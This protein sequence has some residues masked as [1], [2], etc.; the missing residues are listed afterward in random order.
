MPDTKPTKHNFPASVP[1][2][3]A[4][5]PTTPAY[6]LS[7]ASAARSKDNGPPPVTPQRLPRSQ[8][9]QH[10]LQNYVGR[11][12]STTVSTPYTPL[13]LRSAWSSGSNSVYTTP[14]SAASRKRL[15]AS[16]SPENLSMDESISPADVANDWRC[17]SSE[18]G[19]KDDFASE[20]GSFDQVVLLAPPFFHAHT[21]PRRPRAHTLAQPQPESP[22]SPE[23][24]VQ[25]QTPARKTLASLN[26][27]PPQASNISRLKAK[28]SASDPAYPRRRPTFGQ[29]PTRLFDIDENDY[30]PYPMAFSPSHPSTSPFALHDPYEAPRLPS[31]AES[32]Q[33][34]ARSIRTSGRDDSPPRSKSTSCS[35]CGLS[36]PSLAILEPCSHV[37]CSG[38]LTSALNIVG[39][40]DMACAVC[41]TGVANFHLKNVGG[42]LTEKSHRR[43]S[44]GSIAKDLDGLTNQ[45][46][47]FD[48]EGP[49]LSAQ[50]GGNKQHSNRPGE[51]PVLR[52]DNVPW[53]ITP[54]AIV[55]WLRHPVRLVHVLLDRKGKTMSHA[56][57]EMMDEDAARAALRT[58]QNSVLGKGKRARGVTVTRS[59]QEEVMKA[60]F[61]SWRGRFDGTRPSLAGL[62]NEMVVST[63]EAGLITEGELKALAHLIR[64]PDSHFLKVPSL[65]FHCLISILSKFP[66][67]LD[68][69][70]FW[71]KPVRDVLYDLT[72]IAIQTLLKRCED[73]PGFCEPDLP[74]RLLQTA[75]NCQAFTGDQMAKLGSFVNPSPTP[76][77]YMRDSPTS[78][79]SALS[80]AFNPDFASQIQMLAQQQQQLLDAD[81]HRAAMQAHLQQ[82]MGLTHA[83]PFDAVAREF[84]V[85]RHVVEA[86]VQR[87][88]GM[89]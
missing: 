18:S 13:S 4:S 30:V 2:M 21:A 64:A 75:S 38:C 48:I 68:S 82:G 31:I 42:G 89:C 62:G 57:V 33:Q 51:Y 81:Y 56:F 47:V 40:K 71:S 39:E 73:T 74:M 9:H 16:L 8:R 1:M 11:S 78:T 44:S 76:S 43:A 23:M 86:M 50:S 35:V 22:M 70:V 84:G 52:V 54:P 61:P 59:S 63:L 80:D 83:L 41:D 55:A 88:T 79:N 5:A 7:K 32:L 87:L 14:A 72:F 53:D 45:F 60:L 66:V 10:Q 46:S 24:N 28:G 17:R 15:G 36:S 85:D 25:P 26:T 58:A 49:C 77:T 65:P 19:I 3:P 27:P 34:A 69:Q 20:N 37:L 67:D 29:T 6:S 12:P